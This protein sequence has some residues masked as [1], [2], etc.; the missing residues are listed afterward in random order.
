M[1]QVYISDRESSIV[2]PVKELKGFEKVLLAPGESK[3]V[4]I[5]LD[6]RAFSF[7]DPEQHAWRVE[8]GSFDILVGSSSEAIHLS[9]TVEVT[10]TDAPK[11]VYDRNSTVSD[12]LDDPQN[13]DKMEEL[14]LSLR[15]KLV[16][17]PEDEGNV[18]KMMFPMLSDLPLRGLIIFSQGQ[19]TDKELDEF[20]QSLNN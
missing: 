10:E 1:A 5:E 15:G 14:L 12:V 2:R 9:E 13:Q 16:L 17:I 6:P 19:F 18:D 20:I 8:T 4:T 11:M 3:T 7:Y